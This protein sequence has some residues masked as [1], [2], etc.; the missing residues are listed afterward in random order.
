MHC[1]MLLHGY[2]FEKSK[3]KNQNQIKNQKSKSNQKSK[4]KSKIKIKI[5]IKLKKIKSKGYL[6]GWTGGLADWRRCYRV[7]YS[8][9]HVHLHRRKVGPGY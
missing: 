4:I 7:R 6:H 5:K 8:S 2:Q 3:I 1:K 9:F